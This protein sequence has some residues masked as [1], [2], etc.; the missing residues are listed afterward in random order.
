MAIDLHSKCPEIRIEVE[1]GKTELDVLMEIAEYLK[2]QSLR[3]KQTFERYS[4]NA[5]NDDIMTRLSIL[6]EKVRMLENGW[7]GLNCGGYHD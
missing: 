4:E 1:K 3:E 5:K 7:V 2:Q 6:E